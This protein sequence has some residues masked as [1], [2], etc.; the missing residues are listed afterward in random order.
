[1]MLILLGR[2]YNGCQIILRYLFY[3]IGKYFDYVSKIFKHLFICRI[4]HVM[5]IN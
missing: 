1:M 3:S 5:P 2:H 4:G